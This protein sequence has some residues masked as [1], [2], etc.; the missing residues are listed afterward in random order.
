M[1]VAFHVTDQHDG[2]VEALGR[3]L[4]E[5]NSGEVGSSHK[6]NLAVLAKDDNKLLIA[7]LS[8]YSAWGWL[9][10]RWLWVD[11]AFRGRK[12]ASTLLDR[13]EVEARARGCIG[14]HID[15]FNPKAMPT[16]ERHGYQVFGELPDFVA[17]RTRSFLQ[18]RWG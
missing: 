4:S 14:A 11:H 13:A 18:K 1:N 17:G 8:G 16:Y 15:T 3:A 5:Y 9:Y 6:Q 7:G 2:Y 10:I 12:I